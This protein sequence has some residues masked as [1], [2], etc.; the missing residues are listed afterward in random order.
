M[1]IKD[2]NKSRLRSKSKILVLGL[3]FIALV[4]LFSSIKKISAQSPDPADGGGTCYDSYNNPTNLTKRQCDLNVATTT[5]QKAYTWVP[6]GGK[7][8]GPPTT[9]PVGPIT[10]PRPRPT[11]TDTPNLPT[12][13]D[14]KNPTNKPCTPPQPYIL[15]A[16]LPDPDN[17]GKNLNSDGGFY[18]SDKNA[19]G[20]YLNLMIKLIIGIATV[21]AVIMIVI[22][23]MEYM[24]SELISSKEAGRERIRGALLGLLIA[25]GAY[26]LLNT[27]NPDLLKSDIEIADATVTVSLDEQ[28]KTYTGGGTCEPIATGPCSPANLVAAGFVEPRATQA[29]SI[30]NGE[31]RGNVNGASGVDKCV[32]D[33]SFSLGLF[34]INVIAHANEIPGGICSGIFQTTGVGTQGACLEEKSGICIKYNC[35]VTDQAKYNSCRTYITNPANNITFAKNL[36]AA[37]DWGQWGAYNSCRS[38]FPPK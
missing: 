26:A 1:I 14:S 15:L 32:D 3:V 20:T 24:T 11:P 16:P 36:Q 28:I 12:C 35:R 25:L 4:G 30:C 29:S 21:L 37:R 22:G 10:N 2:K 34:Q 5:G 8:P 27:I 31:S 38:K 6:A 18:P 9:P 33:N 13:N 23:G 17:P 7:P 19:L